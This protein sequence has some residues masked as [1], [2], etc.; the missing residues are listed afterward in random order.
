MDRGKQGWNGCLDGQYT[1][2]QKKWT[3]IIRLVSLPTDAGWTHLGSDTGYGHSIPSSIPF[4]SSSSGLKV[5]L[6][7]NVKWLTG[8]I[9][10]FYEEC[11]YVYEFA[12]CMGWSSH[13]VHPFSQCPW[14]LRRIGKKEVKSTAH[15]ALCS[16]CQKWP[17]W[18]K[19]FLF[20]FFCPAAMFPATRDDCGEQ[21]LITLSSCGAAP[22]YS[23]RLLKLY[24][25]N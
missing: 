16:P 22:L 20:F 8:V 6:Q 10:N 11:S 18:P 1:T 12:S 13:W 23:C 14:V 2:F 21:S 24:R 19:Y 9:C 17:P 5:C 25:L 7:I 3:W 4:T 15:F